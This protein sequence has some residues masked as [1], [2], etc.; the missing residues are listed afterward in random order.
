MEIETVSVFYKSQ[1]TYNPQMRPRDTPRTSTNKGSQRIYGTS[2]KDYVSKEL[3]EKYPVNILH[4]SNA[5]LRSVGIHP[6]QKPVELLEYLIRTYTN[7]KETVL[8]NCM[9]S[10][11]TGIACV[12]TDRSFIGIELDKEYFT[13]AK[14]RIQEAIR[15]EP[16]SCT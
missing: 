16:K 1:P 14:K 9:G 10:G 3:K 2:K 13:A 6:T 11:S 8:D 15:Y 12:N 5:G 4:Y 7:K